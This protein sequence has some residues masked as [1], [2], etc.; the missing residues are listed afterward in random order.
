MQAEAGAKYWGVVKNTKTDGGDSTEAYAVSNSSVSVNVVTGIA[1]AAVTVVPPV[2][3][4]TAAA[5]TVTSNSQYEYTS[6][7]WTPALTGNAFA[8]STAYKQTITLTAKSGYCFTDSTTVSLTGT[9]KQAANI[10]STGAMLKF[11]V[12]YDATGKS[13]S[14]MVAA[15]KA[16]IT[17]SVGT[18]FAV[19][20]KVANPGTEQAADATTA[21]DIKT[22]IE[23]KLTALNLNGVTTEVG[24]P[25]ISKAAVPGKP[26]NAAGT[27]GAY[28]AAITI[29]ASGNASVKDTF[30]ISSGV[31]TAQAASQYHQN[32]AAVNTAKTAIENALNNKTVAQ[33]EANNAAAIKSLVEAEIAKLNLNGVTATVNAPSGTP[34]VA[35]VW[36]DQSGTNG[37]FAVTVALSKGTVD[38]TWTGSGDN[39]TDYKAAATTASKAITVTATAFAAKKTADGTVSVMPGFEELAISWTA[40]QANVPV[41]HY[42]LTV[43]KGGAPVEGY[44]AKPMGT[45]TS[46]TVTGLENGQTYDVTVKSVFKTWPESTKLLDDAAAAASGAPVAGELAPIT[47]GGAS[48]VEGNTATYENGTVQLTWNGAP[49]DFDQVRENFMVSLRAVPKDGFK[50]TGWTRTKTAGDVPSLDEAE[51]FSFDDT[52]VTSSTANPLYVKVNE[53]S[54]YT[55]TF[56]TV[57]VV[58]EGNPKL[59]NLKV[60]APD[61]RRLIQEDT[62]AANYDRFASD[63]LNYTVYLTKDETKVTLLPAYAMDLYNLKY[64]DGSDHDYTEPT[65]DPDKPDIDRTGAPIELTLDKGTASKDVTFT[66]TDENDTGKTTTYTVTLKHVDTN[67]QMVL[68]LDAAKSTKLATMVMRIKSAAFESGDFSINLTEKDVTPTGGGTAVNAAG[69][70]SFANVASGAALADGVYDAAA[71]CENVSSLISVDKYEVTNN[72]KT[73]NLTLSSKTGTPITFDADGDIVLKFKLLQNDNAMEG[74]LVDV[75][76]LPTIEI[77]KGSQQ[78]T[79]SETF[80]SDGLDYVEEVEGTTAVAVEDRLVYLKVMDKYNIVAYVAARPNYKLVNFNIFDVNNANKQINDTPILLE[81]GDK[82]LYKTGDGTYKIEI[83]SNGFLTYKL[84]GLK[85][86]GKRVD[87]DAISL[88][89]GDV[90]GDGVINAADRTALVS[91][92]GAVV[93]TDDGSSKMAGDDATKYFADFNDDGLVN[94]KDLGKVIRNISGAAGA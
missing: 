16:A 35:G 41:D 63:K 72:G 73:L 93:D 76:L 29:K 8:G 11:D 26:S 52:G 75:D 83:Q 38:G 25:T 66:L 71:V 32:L 9:T 84:D 21:T 85:V 92:L 58:T 17:A 33:S 50:F 19:D 86:A 55:P 80:F 30:T 37:S 10:V 56:E 74:S 14:E 57:A 28:T 44:N 81:Q 61:G 22:A 23:A 39:N 24:T 31:I 87:L 42:E 89:A 48:K 15:A 67:P 59:Q 7:S 4:A 1:S 20:Q 54:T 6:S 78:N 34:A 46:V 91:L 69:F 64:N 13:S 79:M 27:N 70:A 60:N 94:A 77:N 90:N 5:P 53:A 43:S 47:M 18:S 62:T 65:A 2:A 12:T 3:E 51:S 88:I 36:N 40:P 82:L 45:S 49:L 68:E